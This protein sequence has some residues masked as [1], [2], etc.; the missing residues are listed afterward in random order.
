MVSCFCA[1]P[2]VRRHS[3]NIQ[4]P[5]MTFDILMGIV[6]TALALGVVVLLTLWSRR[7]IERI[8]ARLPSSLREIQKDIINGNKS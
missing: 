2:K 1:N 7:I 8:Y 3:V 6:L 5:L 4:E